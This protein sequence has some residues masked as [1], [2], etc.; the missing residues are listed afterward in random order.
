[1]LPTCMQKTFFRGYGSEMHKRITQ[2]GTTST[3]YLWIRIC[4]FLL[5]NPS[6]V[7]KPSSAAC[8]SLQRILMYG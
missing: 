1:M 8:I 2:K 7:S 6:S 3:G 5:D 4:I